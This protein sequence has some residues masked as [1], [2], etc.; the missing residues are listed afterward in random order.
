MCRI[1]GRTGNWYKLKMAKKKSPELLESR[2]LALQRALRAAFWIC[3][4]AVLY[5][6]LTPVPPVKIS[7]WDKINHAF[8]FAVLGILGW[9]A[10]PAR[11]RTVGACLFVYGCAIEVLQS[12][13]PTR[14]GD[15]HDVVADVVGLLLGAVVCRLLLRRT[16]IM[17]P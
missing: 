14:Q 2:S 12:F 8:A 5:L 11:P 9:T 13:T 10:W 17:R 16:G 7:D 1:V 15:W 6:A 3:A 4:A